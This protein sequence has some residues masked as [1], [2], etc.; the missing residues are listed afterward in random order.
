MR[1][2]KLLMRGAAVAALLVATPSLAQSR[3]DR[4]RTSV[5][6]ATAKVE[7]AQTAGAET[8]ASETMAKAQEALRVA[9]DQ[10]ARDHRDSTINEA[11]RAS[12]LA[13]QA[14][15]EAESV[16]EDFRT[17]VQGSVD[18]LRAKIP[19]LTIERGPGADAATIEVD[20]VALGAASVGQAFPVDPGPH[21]ISAKSP[22]F[23]DFVGVVEL[24]DSE[25]RTFI[26]Q[27]E[28]RD[29]AP[30]SRPIASAI[31]RRPRKACAC[32][33]NR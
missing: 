14:L 2:I 7:A 24:G 30:T 23:K 20:N 16:G 15:A 11:R 31:C 9:K 12:G 17:E 4:A 33:C 10:L 25:R 18:A 32:C 13:D 22:G 8:Y 1:N 19:M 27:L 26:V 21:A 6:E 5:A 28:P 29:P 3:I